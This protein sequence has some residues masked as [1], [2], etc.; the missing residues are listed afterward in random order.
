MS[1]LTLI[2]SQS[3]GS[4]GANFTRS[5]NKEKVRKQWLDTPSIR[6]KKLKLWK[7]EEK[8]VVID[9]AQ[10]FKINRKQKEESNGLK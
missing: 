9:A 10:G 3:L 5:K 4:L 7:E 2:Y 1:N 6:L 8:S